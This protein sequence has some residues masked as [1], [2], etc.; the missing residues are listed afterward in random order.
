MF[1]TIYLIERKFETM[2]LSTLD[3]CV[4]KTKETVF[5]VERE[6]EP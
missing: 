1:E 4:Q 6:L 5:Y 2:N 3:G